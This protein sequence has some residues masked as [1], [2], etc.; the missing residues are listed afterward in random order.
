MSQAEFSICHSEFGM[1][2]AEFGVPH[3]RT[4]VQVDQS[5]AMPVVDAFMQAFKAQR[6]RS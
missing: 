5:T 4:N 2:H 3:I 1:S 6:R